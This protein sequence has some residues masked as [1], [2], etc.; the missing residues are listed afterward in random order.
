MSLDKDN[1]KET[2]NIPIVLFSSDHTKLDLIAKGSLGIE[3]VLHKPFS[4]KEVLEKTIKAI[5]RTQDSSND[6]IP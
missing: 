1:L 5:S 3:E 4:V 2:K 6:C